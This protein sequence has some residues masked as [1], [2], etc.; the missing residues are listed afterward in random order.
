MIGNSHTDS[1]LH[2]SNHKSFSQSPFKVGPL[3]SLHLAVLFVVLWS[4]EHKLYLF[5]ATEQTLPPFSTSHRCVDCRF[6]ATGFLFGCPQ[7]GPSRARS[8]RDAELL[9]ESWL[10]KCAS[11]GGH[12]VWYAGLTVKLMHLRI[13]NGRSYRVKS[14]CVCAHVRVRTT[15]I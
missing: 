5:S 12:M 7:V 10:D 4:V 6:K 15:L 11:L 3:P 9:L 13:G 8:D 1:C 14:T 2:M